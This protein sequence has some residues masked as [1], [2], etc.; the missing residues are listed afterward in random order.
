MK[1]PVLRTTKIQRGNEHSQA[2]CASP[3]DTSQHSPRFDIAPPSRKD[4]QHDVLQIALAK[5]AGQHVPDPPCERAEHSKEEE[6]RQPVLERQVCVR[7][8]ECTELQKWSEKIEQDDGGSQWEHIGP[9]NVEDSIMVI[10]V[11]EAK[12]QWGSSIVVVI[13]HKN[14][15]GGGIKR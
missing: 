11:I 5:I 4:F 10:L 1:L 2:A 13:V 12:I 8:K 3:H 7:Q 15:V 14:E 6:C 9:A